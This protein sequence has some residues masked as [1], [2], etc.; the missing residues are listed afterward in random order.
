MMADFVTSTPSITTI[1]VSFCEDHNPLFNGFVALC[2][3][4]LYTYQTLQS[5]SERDREDRVR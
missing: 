3:N 1:G 5:G 4:A 2:V